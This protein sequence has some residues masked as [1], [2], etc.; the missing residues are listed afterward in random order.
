MGTMH[1]GDIINPHLKLTPF[2]Y[3]HLL[4]ITH[5]PLYTTNLLYR[6]GLQFPLAAHT[7][8]SDLSFG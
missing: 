5:I 6:A 2:W 3:L 8:A 1:Y 4:I 7:I